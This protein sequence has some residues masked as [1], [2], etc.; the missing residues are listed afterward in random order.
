MKKRRNQ[1]VS[2]W[3]L[4][5]RF[6]R[7]AMLP[8][9]MRLEINRKMRDGQ[10]ISVNVKSPVPMVVAILPSD[11]ADQ[12]HGGAIDFCGPERGHLVGSATGNSMKKHG[13]LD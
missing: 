7:I 3:P 10:Q 2:R 4:R 1:R 5:K 9:E 13:S 8:E 6:S 12:L 11:I